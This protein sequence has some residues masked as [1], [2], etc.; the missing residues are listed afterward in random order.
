MPEITNK[1]TT[2][3]IVDDTPDN[4]TLLGGLLK[5]KY[6]VKV[7]NGGE[8]GLRIARSEPHP[9][10]ILLDVMMPDIDGYEVCRA[11]KLDENTVDIPII[12]V[13]AKNEVSDEML[14][15]SIGAVDYIT[16]PI[17]AAITL[18]RVNTHLTLKA[19][20]DAERAEAKRTNLLLNNQV[21][22]LQ[23]IES[24]GQLTAGFGHDLKNILSGVLG[25]CELGQETLVEDVPEEMLKADL[26]HCLD[27]IKKASGRGMNLIKQMLAYSHKTDA[28]TNN[29]ASTSQIIAEVV[30]LLQVG[31]GY[32]VKINTQ[33][34]E[35]PNIH[36]NSNELHQILTN[37]LVNAGH[38]T[39]KNS[40]ERTITIKLNKVTLDH[41]ICAACSKTIN[42]DFIELSIEDNGSGMSSETMINI[43]APFFTT[44]PVGI[45]TGLGLSVS[46]NLIHKA[47]G[48]IR[49]ESELNKGTIFTLSFPIV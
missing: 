38:A 16:K 42:G 14:G 13:T 39:E 4:L 7:A 18:A 47:A 48:H 11:L 40:G 43:F 34:S 21:N 17:N 22:H 30:S 44:K 26:M 46:N 27:Q 1:K 28:D 31:L 32:G 25:F 35:T 15:L 29:V 6:S 20:K 23:K 24:I 33:L 45:G 2:I 5:D 9:D 41:V 37:F 19:V 8:K 49:V 3:L 10:L 36:I 12:F